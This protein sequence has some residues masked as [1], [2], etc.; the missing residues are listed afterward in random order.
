MQAEIIVSIP[1]RDWLTDLPEAAAVTR[2][3]AAAALEAAP[4]SDRPV[5]VGVLLTD[6]GAAGRLNREYR[7]KDGATNVLSFSVG[8]APADRTGGPLLLGDIVLAYG[9][10]ADEARCQGKTLRAHLCHLTVHGVLHL[11]GHDHEAPA[12]ASDMEAREVAILAALGIADPYQP[13]DT[14]GVGGGVDG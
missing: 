5:E 11:L 14:D 3:A 1:C 9:V 4:E 6:D 2:T 7:G 8:D 10:V 12:A 13:P